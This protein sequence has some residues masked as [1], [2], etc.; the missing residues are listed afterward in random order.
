MSDL[1]AYIENMRAISKQAM[2]EGNHGLSAASMYAV[3]TAEEFLKTHAANN[4]H[5]QTE[6]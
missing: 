2:N 6:R 4:N 3:K 1:Q 5:H